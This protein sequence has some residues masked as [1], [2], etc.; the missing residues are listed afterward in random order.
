MTR[1][2]TW[3]TRLDRGAAR[4]GPSGAPEATGLAAAARRRAR[5]RRRTRVAGWPRCGSRGRPAGRGVA[6]WP[7]SSGDGGNDDRTT[8]TLAPDAARPSTTATGGELARRHRARCPDT[9]DVRQSQSTWCADGGEIGTRPRVE[10][11]G[12]IGQMHHAATP[13]LDVRPDVPGDRQPATTS[14]GRSVTQSERRLAGPRNYV[15]GRG[16]RR[17]ASHGGRTGRAKTAHRRASTRCDAIRPPVD[18]NGCPARLT[19]ARPPARRGRHVG[20]PLRRDLGAR[21]ERGAAS[22][23]TPGEAVAGTSRRR[24]AVDGELAAGARPARAHPGDA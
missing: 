22:A 19:P 6:A 11:P 20:L 12:G 21:A 8:R 2:P 16:H 23:R 10:P 9:W 13:L 15:G 4:R 1:A 17:G 14:S 5:Q 24:R 18:P 3:R 7:S